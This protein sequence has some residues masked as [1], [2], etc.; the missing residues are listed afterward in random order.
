MKTKP[1]VETTAPTL[2]DRQRLIMNIDI[3]R[4]EHLQSLLS[5]QYAW[6]LYNN[7]LIDVKPE[8]D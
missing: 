6:Y 1:S 5:Y 4:G 8:E 7:K 2:S 3:S